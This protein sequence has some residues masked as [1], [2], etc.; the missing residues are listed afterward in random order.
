MLLF[1]LILKIENDEWSLISIL[2]GYLI[3]SYSNVRSSRAFEH[4]VTYIGRHSV[5]ILMCDCSAGPIPIVSDAVSSAAD[6][7]GPTPQPEPAAQTAHHPAESDS[8]S[9]IPVSTSVPSAEQYTASA[10]S[11]PSFASS[12]SRRA[13]PPPAA[14]PRLFQLVQPMNVASAAAANATASGPT[15]PDGVGD[16]GAAAR[17]LLAQSQSIA[18][19]DKVASDRELPAASVSVQGAPVERAAASCHFQWLG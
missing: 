2:V 11:A 9:A 15:K 1:I 3:I 10:S 14:K 6:A 4:T 8:S 5:V 17:K 19:K 16:S 18:S 7:K 12:S 13:P